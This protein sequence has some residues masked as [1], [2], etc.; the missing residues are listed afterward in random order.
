MKK[1]VEIAFAIALIILSIIGTIFPTELTKDIIYAIVIPSFILSI[2][3]FI[4]DISALCEQDAK[5]VSDLEKKVSDEAL[6]VADIKL[7]L[8]H[9]GKYKLP[10]VEGVV[11]KEIYEYKEKSLAYLKKATISKDVQ[12]FCIKCKKMCNKLIVGGY[13]AL[14]LSLFLSPYIAK[15]L[16][17]VDL[18]CI[19]LWSLALLYITLELKSECCNWLFNFLYN[20][21][22]KKTENNIQKQKI[23]E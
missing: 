11:P 15:L 7:E 5:R 18:N 2:I 21:Y 10:F 4:S 8:Y 19:T 17:V 23:T 22:T 12:V 9:Q 6:E 20:R 1:G 14:F 13:V 3:S 16:S